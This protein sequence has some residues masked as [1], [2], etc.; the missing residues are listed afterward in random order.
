MHVHELTDRKMGDLFTEGNHLC[1]FHGTVYGSFFFANRHPFA[2]QVDG[3]VAMKGERGVQ[4]REG[5]DT[6]IIH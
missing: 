4:H 5:I 2:F 6:W 1:D 3:R